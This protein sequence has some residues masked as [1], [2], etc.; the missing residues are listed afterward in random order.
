MDTIL[1]TGYAPA[2]QGSSMYEAYKT[3]GVVLEI[4][5][6]TNTLIRAE[7]TF[8]TGL[9]KEYVSRLVSGYDLSNGIDPLIQRIQSHYFTPSTDAVTMAFR[10]AYQRYQQSALPKLG[11]NPSHVKE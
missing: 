1:V 6:H 2:P 5:P 4:N 10:V 8:V 3:A 9:A 7:F 11:I